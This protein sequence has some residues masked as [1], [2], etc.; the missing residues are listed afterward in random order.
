M[1]AAR[2]LAGEMEL[3]RLLEKM[4]AIAIENAGA[5]RG[6]LVLEHDGAPRVH[7]QGSGDRVT[8]AVHK[9]PR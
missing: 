5:E 6:V 8:V 2:V 7:A 4:L 1:K 9:A 3:E